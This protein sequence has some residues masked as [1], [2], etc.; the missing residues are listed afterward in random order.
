MNHSKLFPL[1]ITEDIEAVRSYYVDTLGYP[2]A[3]DMD[4][5]IQVRFGESPDAPELAFMRP[6]TAP[7]PDH[8]VFTGGG[9]IVSIPTE[10]A[11]THHRR[12]KKAGADVMSDPSDKPWGWRSYAVRDPA[13]VILDFFHA[14]AKPAS[15]DATG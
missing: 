5:Y 1:V 8:G 4:A 9:F 6:G 13:G 14:I 7:G 2:L 12:M 10:D 11:D 15:G 3:H